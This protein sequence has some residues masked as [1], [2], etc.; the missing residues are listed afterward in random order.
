MNRSIAKITLG[1]L[2]DGPKTLSA[3]ERIT[4]R[5]FGYDSD[6]VSLSVVGIRAYVI[7]IRPGHV[8]T[9]SPKSIYYKK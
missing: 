1:I 7:R 4:E 3:D 8:F 9:V 5:V 6:F 2:Y